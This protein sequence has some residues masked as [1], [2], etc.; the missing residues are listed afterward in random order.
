MFF[1][2]SITTF[3]REN[4]KKRPP[5]TEEQQ[6]RTV[7]V[8]NAPL[9][10]TR[11]QIKQLFAQFGAIDSVW[12]RSLLHKTEK[13]TLKMFGTDKKLAENLKSTTFYVRFNN[14]EDAKKSIELW[15]L[16][17]GVIN[18]IFKEF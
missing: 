2:S 3:F 6:A 9:N 15:V 4:R 17:Y 5:E 13:L 18:A 12:Q 16:D 11:K 14:V 8:G 10:A 7:F 1:R